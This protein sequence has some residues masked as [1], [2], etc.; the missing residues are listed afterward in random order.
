M[1]RRVLVTG[2]ASG[3]GAALARRFVAA[4]DRVLLADVTPGITG[5]TLED[6]RV[7]YEHLDVRSDE[8]WAG[9]RAWCEQQWDGL[10]I[11][12]NNAG[13]ASGGRIDQVPMSEWRRVVDI[14]LLGVA[15]GCR[16]FVPVM[17][18]QRSGHLVNVASA[19]GLVHPPAMSV[20]SSVKA[21]VVALSESLSYELEPHGIVTSVVCPSFFRT[22]LAASLAGA[23]PEVEKRARELIDGSSLSA[24]EVADRVVSAMA[25]KRFLIIPDKEGRA[26]WA[27]KRFLR[28]AYDRKLRRVARDLH[29]R[30]E[31]S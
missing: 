10:D 14:N 7:A 24:E 29:A 26:G 11:L 2:A 27:G 15:R 23:D 13:V 25:K 19:A 5:V 22:N 28:A 3:L 21:G 30:V 8:D 4:G 17:K 1:S 12:V 20:Y 31:E 16:T 6:D 18:R 9:V